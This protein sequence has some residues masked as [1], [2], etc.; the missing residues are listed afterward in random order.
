[1]IVKLSRSKKSKWKESRG[2]EK[3]TQG[4]KEISEIPSSDNIH[5]YN[6]KF[7]FIEFQTNQEKK[8]LQSSVFANKNLYIFRNKEK[9]EGIS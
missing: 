3:I 5:R 1:M 4:K 9:I 2:Q 6:L 7:I 8:S